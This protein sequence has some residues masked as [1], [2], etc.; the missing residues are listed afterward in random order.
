MG[1]LEQNGTETGFRWTEKAHR[2]AVLV[3]EDELSD[4]EIADVIGIGR[5][6]LHRWKQHPDFRAQVAHRAEDIARSM[7]RLTIAKKHKRVKVLDD[8]H[9]KLLTVIDERAESYADEARDESAE[10]V[11]RRAMR[12]LFG[13]GDEDTPPGAGTGLILKQYKQIGAGRN[14][15]LITEYAV[16]TR[17]IGE[18]RSLHEQAAKELGQW[19][20][21][22]ETTHDATESF[23]EALRAFGRAGVDARP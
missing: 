14:A 4:V 16:D 6:T 3:A 21:K 1:V 5:T 15:Q 17:T 13:G 7:L 19:V 8:L 20:E 2:A 9:R 12:S 11:A 18:I 23:V 22:S 10:A